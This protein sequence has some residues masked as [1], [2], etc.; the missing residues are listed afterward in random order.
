LIARATNPSPP[1]GSASQTVP[2][3]WPCRYRYTRRRWHAL[4]AVL[5]ALGWLAAMLLRQACARRSA[6]PEPRSILLVQL[7]H[8]GDAILSTGLVSGLR[9]R[10]PGAAIDVLAG[11]WNAEVFRACP[12]VRTVHVSRYNR[13]RRGR[14]FGWAAALVVWGLALRRRR[15]DVA[16]DVRGEAPLAL[17]AW[18]SGARRRVGWDCGGGGFLLTDSP[19]Y[20][21][22]RPEVESRQAILE[23]LGGSAPPGASAWAPR[24]DPGTMARRMIDR[25]LARLPQ[26]SRPLVV[27]HVGAGMPAKRWPVEHWRTLVRRLVEQRAARVVL[28]GGDDDRATA[29]AIAGSAPT[30]GLEDWTG[31]FDL[32]Q[33]AALLERAA[34]FVGADSGPA[35]LAAAV[36]APVVVLF[37][38]TNDAQQWR[39][40]GQ[41]VTVVRQAV[42]CAPCHREDCPLVGHPCLSGL[43]PDAVMRAVEAAW[44]VGPA[45]NV[46]SPLHSTERGPGGEAKC[47]AT[48][49]PTP[50]PQTERGLA[51]ST[52]LS[53][54]AP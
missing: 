49:P 18:L 9:A 6:R 10:W 48:S 21:P 26:P 12:E 7:D 27:A 29:R 15:Y 43:T 20:V 34:L 51:T 47:D 19:A 46:R 11:P 32:R 28:V 33:L 24:F 14:R 23:M 41:R 35:H 45:A 8:L 13:F 5:D 42:P 30:E 4:F 17:L 22:G 44:P 3:R 25:G 36:G 2:R 54:R 37:S 1:D 40:W 16:I 52:L 39:P 31:L 53:A 50:A 38:G